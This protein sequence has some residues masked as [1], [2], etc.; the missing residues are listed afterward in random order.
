[1]FLSVERERLDG[2]L[3]LIGRYL[4]ELRAGLR[5]PAAESEL[6]LAEAE[7]H[8]RETVAAGREAGMAEREAQQA[9]TSSFG[10]VRAVVGAHHARRGRLAAAGPLTLASRGT[11]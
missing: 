3:D 10:P 11:R 2:N 9:A 4:A 8:L 1:M 5:V 6:I 7:D